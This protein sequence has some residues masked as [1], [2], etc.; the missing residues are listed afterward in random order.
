MFEWV[1]EF[2]FENDTPSP[3]GSENPRFFAR[4]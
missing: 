4:L 1:Y 2:N 3:D